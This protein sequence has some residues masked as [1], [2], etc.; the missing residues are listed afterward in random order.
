MN[1]T[2][3][4]VVAVQA[5]RERE[6]RIT[7]STTLCMYAMKESALTMLLSGSGSVMLKSAGR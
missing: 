5:Y 6:R 7:F 1:V 2:I 3:Y 4:I